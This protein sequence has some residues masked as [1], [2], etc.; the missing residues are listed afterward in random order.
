MR[1]RRVRLAVAEGF[2]VAVWHGAGWVPLGP[3]LA[4][5]QACG[6]AVAEELAAASADVVAFLAGGETLREQAS[7]VLE[8]VRAEGI[9]WAGTFDPA[10]LLPFEPRSI[11]DFMLYE[12]HAIAA[13]RGIV[14][15]FLPRT[16]PLV[17]SYERTVRRPFPA[18]RP[19]RLWYR[20]P[21]YYHGNPLSILPDGATIP[22]PSYTRALD[23]EL[24]LGLVIARQIR[25]AT[26]DEALGAIGGFVVLNDF[27]ARDVQYPEMTSGFGPSKAKNFA[28]SLGSVVV[29]PD[30]V[31]PVIERL[32][33]TVRVNG[34]PWSSGTT[35]GMQH[36]PGAM[37]AYASLGEQLVP[38]E[39]LGMGTAPGGSGLEIDRWLAPG[40]AIE[41]EIE[42][43]GTLRNVIGQPEGD[44]PPAFARAR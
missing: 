20:Q 35:A 9:N 7:A 3:A 13:A 4:R 14:R 40:D 1:V 18:L 43:V 11:R 19:K 33:F 16:W 21:I 36:S 38:G 34:R 28:S 25:D 6:G 32:S 8:D 30:E 29:T 39:L 37:V 26:P 10:P 27:S 23:Y 2:S 24:E 15:R 31:L 44:Q 41:L 12:Q 22:W 5:Y 17:R 42:R